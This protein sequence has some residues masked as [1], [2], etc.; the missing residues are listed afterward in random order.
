[1]YI[2]WQC[3]L[4][5]NNPIR[6]F[7]AQAST[8]KAAESESARMALLS[9]A[10]MKYI[11]QQYPVERQPLANPPSW[12]NVLC[13]Y[14][15]KQGQTSSPPNYQCSEVKVD[16]G[17]KFKVQHCWK[18]TLTLP[19]GK[20]FTSGVHGTKKAAE[21][22]AAERALELLLF[23]E[24]VKV[25]PV[26]KKKTKYMAPSTTPLTAT[27]IPPKKRRLDTQEEEDPFAILPED[28]LEL[29]KKKTKIKSKFF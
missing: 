24:K 20:I 9:W 25:T 18:C 27:R 26:E 1:M 16:R 23:T 7:T 28:R 21:Q 13:Q 6:Q 19:D 14:L 5:I 11:P 10:G 29:E 4:T 12:K 3:T 2:I 17:Q 15:Q 22:E 8:K